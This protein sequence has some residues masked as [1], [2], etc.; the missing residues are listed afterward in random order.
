M[1]TIPTKQEPTKQAPIIVDAPVPTKGIYQ[2][3][4][5][6]AQPGQAPIPTQPTT[7]GQPVRTTGGIKPPMPAPAPAEEP[8]TVKTLFSEYFPETKREPTSP[9]ESPPIIAQPGQIPQV[10][11]TDP[12]GTTTSRGPFIDS[13]PIIAQPGGML[14]IPSTPPPRVDDGR[15]VEEG[16]E[17]RATEQFDEMGQQPTV[18]PPPPS[19]PDDDGGFVEEG[20]EVRATEDFE[21][22]G[23]QAGTPAPAPAQAAVDPRELFTPDPSPPV[24]AAPE[25]MFTFIEGRERVQGGAPMFLYDQMSEP[26]QVSVDDLR[27]YYNDPEKVNR[28]PEVFGTFENYLAYM[29]ER[30]ELLRSGEYTVGNWSEADPGLS[31]D[32]RLILEGED[33][34]QSADPNDPSN[35][36]YIQ[37]QVNGAKYAAYENWINSDVNKALMQKYG[38]PPVVYSDSGDKFRWNGTAYVKTE[39]V[40]NEGVG[41]YFKMAVGAVMGYYLAPALSSA[42]GSATG[43]T[44]GATTGGITA[45]GV[46]SAAAGQAL[47]SAIV[48]GVTTGSVDMDSLGTAALMGGLGYIGDTIAAEGL[49]NA[50]ADTILS[51]A[52]V[53]L[54]NAIWDTAE[55]LGTDYDT[56]LR[57][58]SGI[59]TGALTGQDVEE[60]ALDAI[61]TY[62]TSELQNLVR[63]T[64]AD[65]MGNIDVDNV[66]REGE[67]SIPIAALNPLIETAVGG[68]FGED[69]G[70]EEIGEAILEGLTYRDPDAVDADMTL[71][72]LDP[73]FDIDPSLLSQFETPEALRQLEDIARATGRNFEDLVRDVVRPIGEVG[74]AIAEQIPEVNVDLPEVDVEGPDIDLASIESPDLPSFDLPSIGGLGGGAGGATRFK[75]TDPGGI[76]YD[77][78]LPELYLIQPRSGMLV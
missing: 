10:T 68:A 31:L 44:A 5:I 25:G 7:K 26:E 12:V 75:R 4:P 58:G 3:P 73:G 19:A 49:A 40:K 16:T 20:G 77:P 54:D 17:V 22:M 8:S 36:E 74:T 52:G 14:P 56:V 9:Y 38:V 23:Q 71:R 78:T 28:L 70:A 21:A 30:E 63:T 43:A 64:Y 66:F 50:T 27:A 13:G 33:L 61:Q 42:I 18:V 45:G 51:D 46:A 67:T 11:P 62:T 53:A 65:S 1:L 59:A 29:Q 55:A 2:S 41:H 32:Q 60:I 76:T 35:P 47:S 39:D 57:I 48:Q 69:V 24:E 72:F 15:T 34:W 37:R 6:I